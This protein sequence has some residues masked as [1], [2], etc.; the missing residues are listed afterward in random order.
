MIKNIGIACAATLLKL[1]CPWYLRRLMITRIVQP[2]LL[3]L[4]L[5]VSIAACV[6]FP[7]SRRALHTPS[8]SDVFVW[9]DFEAAFPVPDELRAHVAFWKAIFTQYRRRQIVL[10]DNWH[11]QVVYD[12][13]DMERTR[14]ISAALAKYRRILMS[15]DAK[16]QRGA[17]GELTAEEARVAALFAGIDEPGKFRKAA[18]Q[19]LR[20]QCG[21]RE[22][23]RKAIQLSGLYQ[24]KFEEI[25]AK[26]GLPV[27]LT[28]IPFVESYFK[29]NAA[30]YAGAAG[31]WQFMPATARMYGLRINGRVDERYDPFKAAD[32]A[33]RLLKANYDLLGSW[34][35]AITAYNHGPA[36]MLNAVKELG[37]DDFGKIAR[38]YRGDKFGFYSRNYYAQFVAAA[39]IMLDE[40]SYFGQVERL[41]PLA[42]SADF[43]RM[44]PPAAPAT[45]L[46]RTTQP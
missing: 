13:V 10:H 5:F 4:F 21:Q 39:Q 17:L 41:A 45:F 28:R 22:S 34:P 32:S 42:N 8:L 7:S 14:G 30:S 11:P 24:E 26:Y 20:T 33:A 37:T 1:A 18:Y 27:V 35:L 16:E 40:Q 23:F 15:L 2:A 44:F 25:F 46:A 31:I 9:Q 12:V 19:R 6:L 3:M 29:H 43:Q 36:G 38:A